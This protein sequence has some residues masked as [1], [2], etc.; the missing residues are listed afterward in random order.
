[1]KTLLLSVVSLALPAAVSLDVEIAF[2]VSEGTTAVKSLSYSSSLE[3]VGGAMVVDGEED[4]MPDD[5][6]MTLQHE[7]SLSVRD[8][9]G[10]SEGG[11]PLTLVRTIESLDD[12]LEASIDDSGELQEVE[13]VLE[14]ALVG[15]ALRW[16]RGEGGEYTVAAVDE[17][18]EV[19]DA[20]LEG[21]TFDLDGLGFLPESGADLGEGWTVP[22]ANLVQILALGGDAHGIPVEDGDDIGVFMLRTVALMPLFGEAEGDVELALGEFDAETGLQT[23]ALEAE[24]S[25]SVDAA[26]YLRRLCREQEFDELE[27][28][29]EV[30]VSSA[31]TIEGSLVW[32][33][34]LGRLE[35]FDLDGEIERELTMS[36]EQFGMVM[37]IV[38]EYEG[39][40]S[41]EYE[42]ETE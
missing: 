27:S 19:K 41:W 6:V 2:D 10:N 30:M 13:V 42:L 1:M 22:A 20:W 25:T 9:Y 15:E 16:T 26:D 8:V 12:A 36:A 7:R 14:S 31:L 18:S 38:L 32:N 28:F 39:E 33:T 17:E 29:E 34:K 11:R 23:I 4:P 37:E 21:L 35:R 5:L 40:A 24:I 3:L